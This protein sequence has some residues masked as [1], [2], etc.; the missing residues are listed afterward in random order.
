MLNNR[1]RISK[2]LLA[3]V[4]G[5]MLSSPLMNDSLQ[6]V[7]HIA[8]AA[9]VKTSHETERAKGMPL[10][11]GDTIGILAPGS[12]DNIKDYTKAI[13]DL[14]KMGYK[15]KIGDSCNSQ[16]GYFAGTDASRA[17]ELN[18]FFADDEIKAILC[19]RGG[20]GSSRILDK[21][22]YDTIARHPKQFIGYSDITALHVAL[23][24]RCNL[25]T[26]H[27]PML[28]S[29]PQGLDKSNPQA[30]IL[31]QGMTGKLYPGELPM[32]QG[33]QL[34]VVFPGEAEGVIMGGNLTLLTSL[35]GTPYEMKGDGILLLLEDVDEDTYRIDRMLW[36]L[37]ES[38]LL[39]RVNGILVGDMT[40]AEDDWQKGDFRLAEVLDHYA[41]LA[42]KPMIKGLPIGH[43]KDN[44]YL[45]FGI[46][47]VMRANTDGTASIRFDEAALLTE[48]KTR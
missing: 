13:R 20:Y 6:A 1:K 11:P 47:A 30:D 29:F 34:E 22:D 10:H 7:D 26:I 2:F 18:K 43:G 39:S 8:C 48:D 19:M 17:A 35:L 38:G 36:Q 16:Y 44:V 42:G 31:L 27:G 28:R 41:K 4:T 32:P 25:S 21:L 24:E 45:P 12:N 40:G 15:V 33:R 23:G 3:T 5:F 14:E 37:W 9:E 46:H